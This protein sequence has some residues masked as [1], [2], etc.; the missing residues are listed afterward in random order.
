MDG[1]NPHKKIRLGY[2]VGVEACFFWPKAG[3]K[4]VEGG[5]LIGFRFCCFLSTVVLKIFKVESQA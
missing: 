5:V 3:G 4:Y 1:V 2:C